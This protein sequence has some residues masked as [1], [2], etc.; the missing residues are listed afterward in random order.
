MHLISNPVSHN[1]IS[2]HQI[3]Y[4]LVRKVIMLTKP[5]HVHSMFLLHLTICCSR[6][7]REVSGLDLSKRLVLQN[8]TS[9]SKY[10]VSGVITGGKSQK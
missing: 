6:M 8:C 9:V 3:L 10:S 7:S 5:V 2:F 4:C 1:L